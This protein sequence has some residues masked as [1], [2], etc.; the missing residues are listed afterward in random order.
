MQLKARLGLRLALAYATLLSTSLL[1]CTDKTPAEGEERPGSLTA[2]PAPAVASATPVPATPP[3]TPPTA[4]AVSSPPQPSPL[5]DRT[6]CAAIR[7]TDYR[8]EVERLWF[9]ANCSPTPAPAQAPQQAQAA[10]AASPQD[11]SMNTPS[12]PEPT[13]APAPMLSGPTL[14]VT[15]FPLISQPPVVCNDSTPVPPASA[16]KGLC[17]RIRIT[18]VSPGPHQ[19]LIDLNI[20][21]SGVLNRVFAVTATSDGINFPLG[22]GE[23]GPGDAPLT[24]CEVRVGI[25]LDGVFLGSNSVF[26][27]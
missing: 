5:P 12:N 7:G 26:L 1:A 11:E 24:G 2:T 3:T 19:M 16:L 13:A 8:S 17:I 15:W 4:V 23:A 27:P 9:A 21:D 10:P 20:C 22:I 18:G 25:S 6:D 14:T